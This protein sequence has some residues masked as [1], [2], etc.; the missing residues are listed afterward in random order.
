MVKL[1]RVLKEKKNAYENYINPKCVELEDKFKA[2]IETYMD[3]YNLYIVPSVMEYYNKVT[4]KNSKYEALVTI[5]DEC[6]VLFM[7]ADNFSL[8]IEYEKAIDYSLEVIHQLAFK[9]KMEK[10]IEYKRIELRRKLDKLYEKHNPQETIDFSK[11]II[12]NK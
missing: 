4:I 1:R 11:C 12:V 9:A 8:Y 2:F 10:D 5:V 6:K 7:F 3:R